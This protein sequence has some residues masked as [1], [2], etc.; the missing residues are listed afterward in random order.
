MAKKKGFEVPDIAAEIE[1]PEGHALAG[2]VAVCSLDIPVSVFTKFLVFDQ[3]TGESIQELEP[4]VD[5]YRLFGD[6]VLKEWNATRNGQPIPATDE[7]FLSMGFTQGFMI[8]GQWLASVMR[9]SAP[10]ADASGSGE[11]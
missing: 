7:G 8:I 10:L 11:Q 9:V 4:L 5:L 1:F 3:M 2:M 6:R